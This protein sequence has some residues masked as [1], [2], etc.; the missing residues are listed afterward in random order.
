MYIRVRRSEY[1]PEMDGSDQNEGAAHR[2][3]RGCPL[4]AIYHHRAD[5]F[6]LPHAIDIERT[7][8]HTVLYELPYQPV[9]SKPPA[10]YGGTE[11]RVAAEPAVTLRMPTAARVVMRNVN[12]TYVLETRW[13]IV[14]LTLARPIA[15]SRQLEE[16]IVRYNPDYR[17]RYQF[18]ALHRLF[19]EQC[20]EEERAAF[21]GQTLPRMVA[22]ALRLTELFPVPIPLLVQGANH[23]V[24]MTQEQAACLLANAF[25][26]TFP[27]PRSSVAKSMP[28]ANFAPLFAGRTQAV[29]EK[30]KCLCHYFRR[31]CD[32]NG[33]P[34]GVLTYERRYTPKDQVPEW[35]SVSACFSP[36]GPPLHVATEGTIEDQGRG[37]LQMVFANRFLGGGVIG[38]GCVQEEI[39]CVINPEL[40]VG[41]LLFESLRETE[42]YFVHGAERFCTYANYASSFTFEADYRDDTPRDASGRRRCCLVG[43]DAMSVER[44]KPDA[45]GQYGER[46]V[47]RELGKAYAG[48]RVAPHLHPPAPGIATGN[49]GCGAFGGHAPLK[50]LLQLMVA[51][52][53]ERP[54]LYFTCAEPGLQE[55]VVGM[56]RFLVERR[57]TVATVF[58]LLVRFAESRRGVPDSGDTGDVYDYLYTHL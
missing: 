53:V 50:A 57:A 47:R 24:S 35:G 21:F 46:A 34:L 8:R 41:R 20:E 14:C 26:C 29:V 42:A 39:R 2:P 22:L 37:L 7:D 36:D 56:Y 58:R 40:L 13:T 45:D 4:E 38:H 16:A 17:S 9:A 11:T 5:R 25:L 28:G 49:W 31:V 19:E 12:G 27:Q 33:M 6:E 43:L 18:L 32:P 15:D 54:L 10:P 3:D 55:Q 1:G 48:F 44:G 23:A 30:L 51:C 52:T